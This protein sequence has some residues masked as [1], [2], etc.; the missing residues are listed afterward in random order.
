M[1]VIVLVGG[2]FLGAWAWER[3]TPLLTAAGHEVHPLTLTGFGDRA[4]LGGES[5]TLTTHATDITAAIETARL[6]EVTLVAHS[7]GGAPATI[8]AA[9]IPRRIARL[10]HVAAVL[11]RAGRTLFDLTPR[12]VQDAIMETVVDGRIPVMSDEIIDAAFGDHGLSPQDRAWL[13]ERGTG[14]PINTYRDPAPDDLSPVDALP[15]TYI[16]CTGDPGGPPDLPGH[17]VIEL[18]SGHWP[19]ITRP[20]ELA[21]LIDRLATGGAAVSG[22]AIGRP[23]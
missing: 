1:S 22:P 7:Y 23:S 21:V 5:T 18:A 17:D 12:A 16:R 6:R 2:S 3:V 15:R 13:R 9:A 20:A 14:Q 8:A 19:M 10:V 4:H 11:P